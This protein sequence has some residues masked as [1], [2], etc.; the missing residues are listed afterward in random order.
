MLKKISLGLVAVLVVAIGGL[1]V[2]A[3]FQP[4]TMHVERS[5][6][7]TAT[8][9]QILPQLHDLQHYNAWN[10]WKGRD[11]SQTETYSDPATGVGAFTEW[12]G[13]ETGT[14]RMTITAATDDG[15]TYDLEF[16][17]PFE[18]HATV[19]FT[20]AAEGEHTRVT[21]TMD[22]DNTF[23]AKVFLLFMDMETELGTVF[24][25]GLANLEA[26]ATS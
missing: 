2:G 10:P 15:V 8:P 17:E 7:L 21:W 18:S 14:G 3:A 23:G 4:D 25:E 16:K 26:A 22:G 5:R 12:N 6:V 20:L 9:A 19:E 11:P 1:L 24:D 13:E